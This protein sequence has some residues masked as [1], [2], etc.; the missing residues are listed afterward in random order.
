MSHM[1]KAEGTTYRYYIIWQFIY[2]ISC[3]I[4]LSMVTLK[5]IADIKKVD[6]LQKIDDIVSKYIVQCTLIVLYDQ[7]L[8]LGDT[9][10]Y[11]V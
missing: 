2:F 6:V 5:E 10:R 1:A 9:S 11:K 4:Y 7:F 3:Y 8:L